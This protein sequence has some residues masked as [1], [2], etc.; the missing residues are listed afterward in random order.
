M[1]TSNSFFEFGVQFTEVVAA[2]PIFENQRNALNAIVALYGPVTRS[3]RG[4]ELAKSVNPDNATA[5][6][7]YGCIPRS[8]W[9]Q[10]DGTPDSLPGISRPTTD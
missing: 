1:L 5:H 9:R 4:S 6:Y 10:M 3:K 8:T 7:P 2:D